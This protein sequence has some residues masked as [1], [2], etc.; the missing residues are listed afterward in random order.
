MSILRW[1]VGA[2]LG[3]VFCAGLFGVLGILIAEDD[4]RSYK[5]SQHFNIDF[6]RAKTDTKLRHKP[7]PRPKKKKVVKQV[8]APSFRL[9]S[10]SKDASDFAPSVG[11]PSISTNININSIVS[12]TA[13]MQIDKAVMPIVRVPPAYPRRAK[14]LKKEGF[15]IVELLIDKKGNVKKVKVV[16]SIPKGLFDSSAIEAVY[17]WKFSPK[18]VDGIAQEQYATQR[19]EFNLQ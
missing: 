17:R 13:P 10:T 12:S 16:K 14:I 1:V 11:K 19:I 4:D 2:G 8:S 5:Q 6:L 3:V 7:P 18:M 9:S 15:V